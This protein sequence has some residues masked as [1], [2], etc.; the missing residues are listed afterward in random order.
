MSENNTQMQ[1]LEKRE[2][3]T[4]AEG[5]RAGLYYEPPVDIYETPDALHLMAD[6]PGVQAQDVEI[7]LKNGLLTVQGKQSHLDEGSVSYREYHPGNYLR[8][9]TLSET[10][11]QEN[12][13][14]TMKH[15]VLHL[16]LPKV[17]KMRPRR[18]EVQVD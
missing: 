6:M 5:T 3:E 16:R 4:E 15:G 2:L 14:A 12:I 9:F 17:A 18:I 1:P 7:D 8:R 11:D 10:I 13:Q